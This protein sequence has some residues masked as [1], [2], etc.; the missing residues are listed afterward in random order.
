M[1][2][3]QAYTGRTLSVPAG[4]AVGLGVSLSI[5]AAAIGVLAKLVDAETLPWENMGYGI[6]VMLLAASFF[7]ALAAYARV[8]RQRLMVCLL[9][10]VVFYGCL[11][12]FTALFFGGQFDGM[13]VSFLL[14]LAGSGAAGLLG[15][16]QGRG[17]AKKRLR[18]R[19]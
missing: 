1:Q 12:S 15:L 7:G 5:T 8:K 10:G 3:K 18:R 6:M 14:T 4:L 19:T 16:R 11:L 9:A 13:G 2:A 17:G